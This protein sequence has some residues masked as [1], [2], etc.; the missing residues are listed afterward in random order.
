VA[1]RISSSVCSYSSSVI[2]RAPAIWCW[3]GFAVLLFQVLDDGLD[4]ARLLVDRARDPIH[5]SQ[6]IEYG[7][8][9]AH[10]SVALEGVAALGI[11][12][13]GWRSGGRRGRS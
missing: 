3:W 7:A 5:A 8:P 12:I 4:L 1:G 2:L 9:D 10:S 6:I 11:V 13:V